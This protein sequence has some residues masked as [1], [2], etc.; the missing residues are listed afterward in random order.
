MRGK[1][2]DGLHKHAM[3]EYACLQSYHIGQ[4]QFSYKTVTR[5][6]KG[7][8]KFKMITKVDLLQGNAP[9]MHNFKRVAEDN[10]VP[11]ELISKKFHSFEGKP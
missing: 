11:E 7:G 5:K 4:A 1:Y 9:W 3:C 6:L 10:G 8:F 2:G